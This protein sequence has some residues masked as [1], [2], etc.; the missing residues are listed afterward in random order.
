MHWLHLRDHFP[1]PLLHMAASMI[2]IMVPYVAVVLIWEHVWGRD[3]LVGCVL[4]ERGFPHF[5]IPCSNG[6]RGGDMA[7]KTKHLSLYEV[8]H[9]ISWSTWAMTLLN[10]WEKLFY[11][12]P[13]H[14]LKHQLGKLR[15]DH[16]GNYW[17]LSYLHETFSILLT[18]M[19]YD[20]DSLFIIYGM[21]CTT[22][23]HK[24]GGKIFGDPVF[25]LPL[26]GNTFAAQE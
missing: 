24:V 16:L 18:W 1:S 21:I 23:I 8:G 25:F 15:C 11:E 14:V 13:C 10:H 7:T 26:G 4:W 22:M 3:T 19:P 12:F 9:E 6:S 2:L 5:C 17:Y 20:D